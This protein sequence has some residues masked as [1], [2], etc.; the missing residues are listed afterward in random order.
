MGRWSDDSAWS[1]CQVVFV[2]KSA[3]AK[4]MSGDV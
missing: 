2:A 4:V 1:V 3:E